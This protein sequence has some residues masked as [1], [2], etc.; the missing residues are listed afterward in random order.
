MQMSG[1]RSADLSSHPIRR[2][3]TRKGV[4]LTACKSAPPDLAQHF[5]LNG[6]DGRAAGSDRHPPN[7][8]GKIQ[9]TNRSTALAFYSYSESFAMNRRRKPSLNESHSAGRMRRPSSSQSDCPVHWLCTLPY[10]TCC[11]SG[12]SPSTSA[13]I[14]NSFFKCKWPL[15]SAVTSCFTS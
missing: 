7:G 9:S 12:S 14:E 3:Q 15:R 4:V 10:D 2:V 5:A 8:A 6:R 11:Q 1:S 13:A